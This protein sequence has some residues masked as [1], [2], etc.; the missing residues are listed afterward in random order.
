MMFFVCVKNQSNI[1][2]WTEKCNN[3]VC[4]FAK[5]SKSDKIELQTYLNNNNVWS[6]GAPHDNAQ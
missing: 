2:I 4:P 1:I 5:I 6:D 3:N